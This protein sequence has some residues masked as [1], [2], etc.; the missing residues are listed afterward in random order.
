MQERSVLPFGLVALVLHRFQ[1]LESFPMT[2]S[3][4]L[5]R[6]FVGPKRV[7]RFTSM[8]L[9]EHLFPSHPKVYFMY[10]KEYRISD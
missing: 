7:G 8:L 10:L 3:V 2:R 1:L 5:S 9:S 4:R 6:R